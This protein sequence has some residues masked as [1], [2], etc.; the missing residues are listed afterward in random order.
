M[1]MAQHPTP[2]T[3]RRAKWISAIDGEIRAFGDRMM[4]KRLSGETAVVTD[5]P[6]AE[7]PRTHGIVMKRS[8]G[9]FRLP[10]SVKS[11]LIN[12]F[13]TG[14]RGDVN[15]LTTLIIVA[16]PDDESIGAGAR[17]RKLGDAWV[18]DV[19]D[20]APRDVECARRHGYDTP[21]EYA[22][23]RRTELENAMALA[24]LPL[25][26]LIRLDFADGEVTMRLAELCLKVTELIDTMDPDVVLTHPYEGGHTDHDATA[27]AVHLACGVLSREG[28][29]PPAILELALYN[30]Q[31]G[32]K[33]LQ[34]FVPHAR[35]DRGQ[36]L[37]RLTAAERALKQAI[38][39]CFKS[40]RS[41]LSGFST[42]FEKFRPAPRYEFTQPPHPGILNYERYGDP[43]RGKSW[44]AQAERVL[45]GLGMRRD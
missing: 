6:P 35:A 30:A 26:R 38:F 34:Q 22:A 12:R 40:Q 21:E 1:S 18:V 15:K 2:D 7:T 33:V 5:A 29:T 41:V 36:L 17:L 11:D 13:I 43:D 8:S 27:F 9:R 16:H 4:G 37:V 25:E 19:T 31:N 3:D 10:R 42:E 23:A 14:D 28:I 44:R 39:D 24:G 32:S 45:K 20:G